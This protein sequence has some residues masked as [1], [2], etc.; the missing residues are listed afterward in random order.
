MESVI[1]EN[2]LYDLVKFI[3]TLSNAHKII[4]EYSY[5]LGTEHENML[6]E[7]FIE[8]YQKRLQNIPITKFLDICAAPGIYSKYL[9][10]KNPGAKGVGISLD[11]KEGGHAFCIISDRYEKIYKN[12]YQIST[13]TY[14]PTYDLCMTSCIPYNTSANSIDE[15]RIIFKSLTVCLNTLKPHGTLIINFSFKEIILAINFIYL[16]SKLFKKIRLFKSTKLWI[17]QRTFYIIGYDYMRDEKIISI[18]DGYMNDFFTFYQTSSKNLLPSITRNELN[19]II[20]SLEKD[21]F[22]VQLKTY[23]IKSFQKNQ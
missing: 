23:L 17:L 6:K 19:Y 20:K 16:I 14:E 18:I 21:V 12:V 11:P 2:N 10:D 13:S 5:E 1:Y 3:R 4:K 8:L 15:Y 22:M 9:L 7:L